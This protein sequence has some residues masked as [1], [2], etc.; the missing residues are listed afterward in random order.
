ML[1]AGGP[2]LHIQHSAHR[3]PPQPACCSPHTHLPQTQ[4]RGQGR[5]GR[6]GQHRLPATAL[7]PHHQRRPLAHLQW[8]NQFMAALVGRQGDA[9]VVWPGSS[10]NDVLRQTL[11]TRLSVLKQPAA[12]IG[13]QPLLTLLV[14]AL[15]MPPPR[16]PVD[17]SLRRSGQVEGNPLSVCTRASGLGH[18]CG[19]AGAV[20]VQHRR[21]TARSCVTAAAKYVAPQTQPQPIWITAS[22]LPPEGYGAVLAQHKMWLR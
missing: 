3:Q 14:L 15:H 21:P 16:L 19:P 4:G 2:V 6:R 22:L 7:G 20:I 13:Q 18:S 12:H 10:D 17:R 11:F 9:Q 5:R 1:G 8:W